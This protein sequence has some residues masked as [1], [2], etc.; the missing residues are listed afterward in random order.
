MLLKCKKKLE[1]AF[2]REIEKHRE[3]MIFMKCPRCG[4]TMSGGVCD[5]CGFPVTKI[6]FVKK[7]GIKI[8][9]LIPGKKSS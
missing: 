3:E 6:K 2:Q 5:N 1:R 7:V 8:V 9:K 4:A